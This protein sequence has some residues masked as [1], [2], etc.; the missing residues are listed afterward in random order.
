M[1]WK[2]EE[3]NTRICA[4]FTVQSACIPAALL[5]LFRADFTIKFTFQHEPVG[6]SFHAT[7]QQPWQGDG[8]ATATSWTQGRM[9]PAPSWIQFHFSFTSIKMKGQGRGS[10]RVWRWVKRN[11]FCCY[12]AIVVIVFRSVVLCRGVLYVC[13]QGAPTKKLRGWVNK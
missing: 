1:R 12:F 9:L 8:G 5:P 6:S 11:T 7:R 10:N 2:R 3:K 13:Y 4:R